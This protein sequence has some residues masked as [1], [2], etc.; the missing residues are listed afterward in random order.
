MELG[1]QMTGHVGCPNP[2]CGELT[3]F[4]NSPDTFYS[5]NHSLPWLMG[6]TPVAKEKLGVKSEQIWKHDL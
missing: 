4:L 1:D 2:A 5:L 6:S 3:L